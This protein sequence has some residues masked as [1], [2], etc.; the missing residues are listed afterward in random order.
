MSKSQLYV[1][2]KLRR[3]VLEELTKYLYLLGKIPSRTLSDAMRYCLHFTLREIVKS[4]EA[5]RFSG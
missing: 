1:K 4:I 3:E 2:L 5:E